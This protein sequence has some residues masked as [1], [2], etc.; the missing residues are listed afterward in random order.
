MRDDIFAPSPLAKRFPDWTYEE[1]AFYE[2][3]GSIVLVGDANE[4]RRL[5]LPSSRNY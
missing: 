4:R 1:L 3:D 2:E 5:K